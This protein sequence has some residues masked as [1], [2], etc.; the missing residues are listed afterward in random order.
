MIDLNGDSML[1][2]AVGEPYAGYGN[3]SYGGAV[4]VFYGSMQDGELVG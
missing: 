1:D 2:L 3:L 4:T